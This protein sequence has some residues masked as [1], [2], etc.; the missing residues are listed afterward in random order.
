VIWRGY[1]GI[2]GREINFQ[3]F[4]E[5]ANRCF[6]C[7]GLSV[8][9]FSFII[10]E[11]WL[12]GMGTPNQQN[13]ATHW[14]IAGVVKNAPDSQTFDGKGL[15]NHIDIPGICSILGEAA[16]LTAPE[17]ARRL[18]RLEQKPFNKT[19]V[20]LRAIRVRVCLRHLK[21]IRIVESAPVARTGS[22]G[23]RPLGWRL[24]GKAAPT[25]ESLG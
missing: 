17:I 18:M 14:Q 20:R 9:V 13:H 1:L 2:W 10:R 15:G 5:P 8:S 12:S 19:G 7:D 16:G 4:P 23:V 6:F 25:D 21:S 11:G 22:R 3:T 24:T